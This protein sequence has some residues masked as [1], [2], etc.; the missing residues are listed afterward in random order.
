MRL[1]KNQKNTTGKASSSLIARGAVGVDI[2]Q[3][4]IKM[5][6]LSGRSLNQIQLEKYAIIKLPKNIIK[7]TQ[8]QDYDLLV[9]YLQQAYA[10]LHSSN[11]NIVAA[12]PQNLVTTETLVHTKDSE[13]NQED[14][15]DYELSQIG[16]LDEMNYDYQVLGQS[17]LP[18]GQKIL[19]AAVRKEDL[20]P[21][22]EIFESA[23][24][25]LAYMDVDVFA[26]S[27]AFSFWINHHT[28]ELEEEK[29]AIIDISDSQMQAI[30]SQ[31]GNI[32]Y[33]Q[34]TPVSNDQLIQ[35]IQRTYQVS[36]EQAEAMKSGT[37]KPSDYQAQIADRFNIQ[38][39]QEIQRVLQFYYTTQSSDQFSSVRQIFL[40]GC[41]SQ[42]I[43]L[44]ETVFSQTNTA[45]QCVNPITYADHG[46]RVD[47]SQL[48]QDASSL[49]TA[50]GLA[51]RGL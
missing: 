24:L 42:Q 35:L 34:E 48:Q 20:E 14:F 4:T 2:S 28:P 1:Q 36:E 26:L 29:I 27:N 49:T 32:L 33:K 19:L 7:G 41:A 23:D 8:I 47:L 18:L 39:A 51:L 37:N 9:S 45:C 40:T 31:G 46:S 16:A 10:Q 25:N 13:Q 44:A 38:V 21:R 6:Q 17:V 30:V 11:K 50:F 12:M 43:G 5:V 22:I 3:N 15:I